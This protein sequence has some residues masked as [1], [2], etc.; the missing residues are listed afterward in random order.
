M[1]KR[2]VLRMAISQA[3]QVSIPHINIKLNY[4]PVEFKWNGDK[5]VYMYIGNKWDIRL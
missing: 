3:I 1:S 2:R 4:N 5:F